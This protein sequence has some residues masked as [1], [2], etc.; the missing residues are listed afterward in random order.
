M[1]A[2][3]HCVSN[4][5]A[6]GLAPHS[7]AA[8]RWPGRC[9]AMACWR[10]ETKCAK[11]LHLG[12][13]PAAPPASTS[14]RADTPGHMEGCRREADMRHCLCTHTSF[15]RPHVQVKTKLCPQ[16]CLSSTASA[17]V[18]HMLSSLYCQGGRSLADV[19]AMHGFDASPAAIARIAVP[20]ERIRGCSSFLENRITAR[21]RNVAW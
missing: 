4:G 7:W 19:L 5:H 1:Q 18:L 11:T 21:R 10:R 2:L 14:C 20:R 17:P 12:A 8:A 16:A 15:H 6:A 9:S 3:L 13:A